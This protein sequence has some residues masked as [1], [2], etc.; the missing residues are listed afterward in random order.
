MSI[1]RPFVVERALTAVS[2]WLMSL[3]STSAA[4]PTLDV[5]QFA[6]A[7]WTVGDGF[8][9]GAIYSIA[10]TPDGY[11]WP[12][13]EFGLF[14]FD[15]VTTTPWPPDQPIATEVP[16]LIAARDG[17]LWI[18]MTGGLVSWKDGHLT[19]YAELSGR[20]PLSLLHAAAEFSRIDASFSG[21][22]RP[23]AGRERQASARSGSPT[24]RSGDRGGARRGLRPAWLRRGDE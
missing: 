22:R 17:M 4:A 16:S 3:T 6:H 20:R 21:R 19:R 12:G 13:T 8:A 7:T 24:C 14:R 9:K 1:R 5:S 18:G 23:P 2:V 11:L 10:Q 15:G